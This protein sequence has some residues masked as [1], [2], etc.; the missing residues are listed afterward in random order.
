[1]AQAARHNE[2]TV[3]NHSGV[4]VATMGATGPDPARV[5][6]AAIQMTADDTPVSGHRR[7]VT[8]ISRNCALLQAGNRGIRS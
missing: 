5:P 2:A 6:D 7:T 8:C 3:R 1:M 4:A